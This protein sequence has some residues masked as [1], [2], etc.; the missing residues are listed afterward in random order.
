MKAWKTRSRKVLLEHSNYLTVENHSVE[1]PDGRVIDDWPWVITPDFVNVLAVTRQGEFI[2]FRQTK[3]GIAGP[4]LAPVGGYIEP[5]EDTLSAAKRELLEETGF[6]A[7]EWV[8]LGQYRVDSNRGAGSA[9]FYLALGAEK[10]KEADSD[11]LEEQQLHLLGF[12]E[13][14]AALMSFQFKAL[15]W[16]AIVAMA[17][18][19]YRAN[20]LRIVQ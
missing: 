14:E 2:V 7:L 13:L 9:H 4:S 5:G 10:V 8:S 20:E 1:L 17:L 19:Y 6:E 18:Q 15:P 12:T 11:D 16:T 3:Y